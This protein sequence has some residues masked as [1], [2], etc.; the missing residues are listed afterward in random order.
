MA[1]KPGVMYW[2]A[3]RLR[4]LL[5]VHAGEAFSLLMVPVASRAELAKNGT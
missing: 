4:F 5:F 2:V 3:L 1:G